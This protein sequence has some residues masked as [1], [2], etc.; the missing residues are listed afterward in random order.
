MIDLFGII[1]RVVLG[2]SN[3]AQPAIAQ[4]IPAIAAPGTTAATAS[5][6]DVVDSVQKFYATIK[7]VTAQFRQAVT[8]DTFGSTKTSDGTVWIMKPGKMRWDYLEKKKTKVEV[9]KSFISNGVNLYVVEHD[10]MQVVQKNLANDLMPV[11][12]SFLYGKGD[13]K[14]EFNAELE[15]SGKYGAKGEVVLKLTPKKPSAQYKNLILVVSPDNYRVT[16]SIIIDSS[17]NVNH[18]R[19]FTPDFEKPIKDSWFEFDKNS[20]KNYRVID[21]D[22]EAKQ[23]DQRGGSAALP[24]KL[25]AV[26]QTPPAT[27]PKK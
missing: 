7:Q 4:S 17:N 26:P 19:F 1:T 23:Q 16:Q 18:F 13:L 11:A 20:V 27:P 6:N 2:T 3:P 21:A 14:S 25:P 9:K 24:P 5:A 10:N 15:K 8:N 22:Q 12:V